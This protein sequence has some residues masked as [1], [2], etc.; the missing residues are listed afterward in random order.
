PVSGRAP[1]HQS[2]DDVTQTAHR[3]FHPSRAAA[4]AAMNCFRGLPGVGLGGAGGHLGQRGL[5]M[6]FAL[7]GC[8]PAFFAAGLHG[9]RGE[10]RLRLRI[11][12]IAGR[13]VR[14]ARRQRL[15]I[16]PAWPWASEIITA[17]TRLATLAP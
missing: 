3:D 12:A 16:D 5:E 4:A 8:G 9:A 15:K 10:L 11:L 7:A 13:L 2:I 14:T 17:H 6:E 1:P